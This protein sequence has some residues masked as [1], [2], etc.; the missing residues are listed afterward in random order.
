MVLPPIDDPRK[1]P[2]PLV[3]FITVSEI[4][5]NPNLRGEEVLDPNPNEVRGGDLESPPRSDNFDA[6]AKS[7]S[8]LYK[9]FGR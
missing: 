8:N 1:S 9:R 6:S 5:S 2:D 4:D 7:A 3:Y